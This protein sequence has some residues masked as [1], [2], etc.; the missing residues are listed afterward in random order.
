MIR[1]TYPTP[2]PRSYWVIPGI[3]L[4]GEFPG[5][6]SHVET[7][8]KISRLID[9]GIRQIINLMEPQETDH[10]GNL[11]NELM[12]L[13]SQIAEE[14][15]IPVNC[16]NFPVADLNVPT[17]AQ[18]EEI[19]DAI[20]T[21][22]DNRKPVYV[23]CWGGIGRTGTVVGC[24][25]LKNGMAQ[26]GDVFDI[27]ANL[28]QNDPERHRTSPETEAQ[29]QFVVNCLDNEKR[30]PTLLSRVVG[31]MLGGAVGDA[32]GAPV[33]F[34][35]LD[36]IRKQYGKSGI[37]NLEEA[38]GRRGA[39]TDDTQMILFT[40]EGLILSKVRQEFAERK[41]A[42]PAIYHAY[43]RWLYTQDTHRQAQLIK[44]YGTC[45]VVDGIL[46]GHKDLFSQRAP[47]NSCLSAL[48]SGKMGTMDKAINDSKGCGGVM[49]VAPIGLAYPDA[50]KAFRLGCE[51]AAI[52]HGHPTG[53]LSAGFLSSLISRI[54]S[55]E[56]ISIAISDSS[57]ILRTHKDHEECL[58]AVEG[59]AE[60]F[61]QRNPSP[62]AVETLG[63][64]WVAEEAL[65]IG[66]YCALVAGD[67][68]R[69][70]V[71]LAVNHSGDSDS[72]G[73]I[74]GNILGSNYGTEVIPDE[75]LS[76]IELK[77]VIE[78]VAVDL[79]DQFH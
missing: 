36:G 37:T 72:T 71:L 61:Q 41:L 19:L 6:K 47:G 66:L 25:L 65:A 15:R 18:M 43:L 17:V 52:T 29:R 58:K 63:A 46:T 53:Y 13:V 70:G 11:F 9:C 4:A 49:R 59:A 48:R 34:L 24:F 55:G 62:E 45:A 33:E 26:A 21:S 56:T 51:S 1:D 7:Q 67:D 39:I 3:L 40:A 79:V 73:S 42:V 60:M 23:H 69:R 16:Q 32:L 5:A 31:C 28:R 78:E 30:L 54:V 12:P 76:D 35:K 77:D 75:W 14:K 64:G 2:F 20:T 44:D 38:Y 10:S 57:Q 68:F 27:I 8:D 74:T 50:E 22:I